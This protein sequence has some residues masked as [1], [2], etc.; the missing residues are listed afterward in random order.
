MFF[1]PKDVKMSGKI[2]KDETKEEKEEKIPIGLQDSHKSS[3]D[4]NQSAHSSISSV[5]DLKTD[6][7]KPSSPAKEERKAPSV[8]ELNNNITN[9]LSK[10]LPGNDLSTPKQKTVRQA[11]TG[12]WKKSLLKLS[13]KISQTVHMLQ[14]ELSKSHLLCVLKE[15]V[16]TFSAHS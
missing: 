10:S 8:S 13:L 4:E 2:K 12:E 16:S 15:T 5:E 14:R 6:I 3:S 11:S 9:K 7:E 1:Q